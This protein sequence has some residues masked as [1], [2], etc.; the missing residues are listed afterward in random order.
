MPLFI[1]AGTSLFISIAITAVGAGIGALCCKSANYSAT[2]TNLIPCC[3]PKTKPLLKKE[4]PN[5]NNAN[6]SD[7]RHALK[8]FENKL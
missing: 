6:I 2:I 5:A 3:F 7:S 4:E 1:A 8:P